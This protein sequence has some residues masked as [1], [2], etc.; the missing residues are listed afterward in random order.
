MRWTQ[1]TPMLLTWAFGLLMLLALTFVN[2]QEQT[3]IDRLQA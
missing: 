2:F 3:L 1:L